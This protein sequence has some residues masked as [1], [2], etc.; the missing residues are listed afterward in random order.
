MHFNKKKYVLNRNIQFYENEDS[1]L[2]SNLSLNNSFYLLIMSDNICKCSN[3]FK[4]NFI[5]SKMKL[6]E[7]LKQNNDKINNYEND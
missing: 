6:I 2:L 7:L 3:I 1:T 5:L 4:Q